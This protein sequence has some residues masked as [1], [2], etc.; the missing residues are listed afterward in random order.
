MIVTHTNTN[1]YLVLM[2]GANFGSLRRRV[3]TTMVMM[4]D[5]EFVPASRREIANQLPA[6]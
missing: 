1:T 4:D 5:A 3:I 6:P 2:D